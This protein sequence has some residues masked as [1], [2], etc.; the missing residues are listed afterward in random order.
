MQF[1]S[2]YPVAVR[3]LVLGVGLGHPQEGFERS[4]RLLLD[5]TLVLLRQVLGPRF[6][7]KLDVGSAED[8]VAVKVLGG[9]NEDDADENN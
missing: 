8:L 3:A 9:F 4:P 5:A 1:L 7:G 6:G 2:T